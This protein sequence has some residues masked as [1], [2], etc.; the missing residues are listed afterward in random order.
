MLHN[1][2]VLYHTLF[3]L[4]GNFWQVSDHDAFLAFHAGFGCPN[5][6]K[7]RLF[8]M[9]VSKLWRNSTYLQVVEQIAS[10]I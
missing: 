7:H 3:F 10:D 4:E 2:A 5:W 8:P 1:Y 6:K 9:G